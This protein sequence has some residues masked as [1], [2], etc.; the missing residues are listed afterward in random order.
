MQPQARSWSFISAAVLVCACLL[1]CASLAIA[2]D[3]EANREESSSAPEANQEPTFAIIPESSPEKPP[4]K[5]D[6]PL[7]QGEPQA[8]EDPKPTP[9]PTPTPIPTPVPTPEPKQTQSPA[10]KSRRAPRPMGSWYE[11]LTVHAGYGVGY[12]LSNTKM[13]TH[14][15]VG[16]GVPLGMRFTLG[17]FFR[18][19]DAD[20]QDDVTFPSTGY[21]ENRVYR[22]STQIAGAWAFY[23]LTKRGSVTVACGASRTTATLKEVSTDAPLPSTLTPGQTR[24]TAWHFAYRGGLNYEYPLGSFSLGSEVGYSSSSSHPES[25]VNE[26]YGTAYLRYYSWRP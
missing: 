5:S 23:R 6:A 15:E 8:N 22:L 4:E 26:V 1:A 13:P 25:Q 18:Q 20:R 12:S 2:Q 10:K 11:R 17:A 21:T 9:T 3:D 24:E 19:S 16:I 7:D 14:Y